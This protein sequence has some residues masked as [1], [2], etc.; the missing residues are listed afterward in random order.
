ML[1]ELDFSYLHI[2]FLIRPGIRDQNSGAC[3]CCEM[4]AENCTERSMLIV[5][6]R[7]RRVVQG[8]L[9]GRTVRAKLFLKVL[10]TVHICVDLHVAL[11][12]EPD[13]PSRWLERYQGVLRLAQ[14]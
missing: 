8:P 6:T 10:P 4:P 11:T 3:C 14:L 12:N 2:H 1:Y 7:N 13:F 5:R 9:P